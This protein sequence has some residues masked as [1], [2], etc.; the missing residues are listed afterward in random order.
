VFSSTNP[1]P[2]ELLSA[3][4]RKYQDSRRHA[5]NLG[6]GEPCEEEEEAR[7]VVL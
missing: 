1:E 4:R 2:G 7:A 6:L 3:L 5:P